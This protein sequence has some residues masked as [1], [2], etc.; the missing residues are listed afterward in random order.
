MVGMRPDV[1][2]EDDHPTTVPLLVEVK[3][4]NAVGH[5]KAALVRKRGWAMIEID[6]SKL[7]ADAV[8]D[9]AFERAVLQEAPRFWIHSPTAERL[10]EQVQAKVEQQVADR[11]AQIL[12]ERARRDAIRR[13]R[14]A[15][16][17][18]DR[19]RKERFRQKLRAP[20]LGD[21]KALVELS[22]PLVARERLLQLSERDAPAIDLARG[23]YLEGGA[24]PPFLAQIPTGWQLVDAHPHLW[25]LVLWGR[26]VRGQPIGTRIQ[27]SK[28]VPHLGRMFKLQ[29]STE[30]A[31]RR[32]AAR[33]A[34]GPVKGLSATISVFGVLLGGLGERTDPIPV[35]LDRGV[36][37]SVMGRLAHRAAGDGRVRGDRNR[38]GPGSL[39]ARTPR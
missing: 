30:A 9:N 34:G 7:D 5:E 24:L 3:V 12:A 16:L 38:A 23:R 2:L 22:S 31:V 13:S 1:V 6:L 4:S 18:A 37:A 14:E 8:L 39:R 15:K 29:R 19:R 21:L 28:W 33:L 32:A 11:N 25:Q 36:R 10:F 20:H 35:R 27:T 17:D 26:L